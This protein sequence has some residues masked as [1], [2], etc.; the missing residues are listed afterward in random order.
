MK[1][2]GRHEKRLVFL[3]FFSLINLIGCSSIETVHRDSGAPPA[4]VSTNPN[5]TTPKIENPEVEKVAQLAEK[6]IATQAAI[7]HD[8]NETTKNTTAAV[9][10][11]PKG[12]D[13]QTSL[14][15]L[16]NGNTRFIKGWKRADSSGLQKL[17][18]ANVTSQ[19]HAIIISDVD[20]RVIPHY[21]F[22]QQFGEILSYRSPGPRLSSA[23]IVSI[24]YAIQKWGIRH[25]VLLSNSNC[26]FAKDC[27]ENTSLILTEMKEKSAAIKNLTQMKELL[28]SE[29]FLDLKKGTVKFK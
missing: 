2:N 8:N 28:I 15:W 12:T 22:D 17:F 4:T 3:I 18:Q 26:L 20:P 1:I 14:R 21:I 10:K 9:Y 29:A 6:S 5:P 23:D 25:V 27:S 24:E 19:P 13:W 7:S 11:L 16:K